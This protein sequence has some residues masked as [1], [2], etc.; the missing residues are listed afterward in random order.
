[1]VETADCADRGRACYILVH[2]EHSRWVFRSKIFAVYSKSSE[3]QTSTRDAFAWHESPDALERLI[4]PWQRVTV[5]QAPTSLGD[6][7][8]AVLALH[9]GPMKLR[10]VARHRDFIDRGEDGGEFTDE[11]V[12]GPFASWVHRHTVRTTGPTSCV[13]D[14][15]IEY[16]LPLGRLGE[17]LTG[18]YVR[19]KLARMFD[20]RHA[21]T[22]SALRPAGGNHGE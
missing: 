22:I 7:A 11:Q 16:A 14:D 9:I 17:I 2:S 18:W 8:I 21:I 20:Y 4:P 5:E 12:S 19:K 6:G 3:I 13:L 15:R 10:W 1:M